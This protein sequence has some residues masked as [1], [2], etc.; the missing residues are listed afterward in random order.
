MKIGAYVKNFRCDAG[1]ATIELAVMFPIVMIIAVIMINALTFFCE[2]S[3][4]D[5]VFKETVVSIGASPAYGESSANTKSILE[6]AIAKDFTKDF[7]ESQVTYEDIN[8]GYVSFTGVLKMYPTLFGLGLKRDIFGLALPPL[9]HQQK[10][11]I[12]VYKPGVIF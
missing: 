6:D 10:I 12:D 1:Q 5:R 9:E 2:C 3:K 7:L 11:S 4:F 8:G